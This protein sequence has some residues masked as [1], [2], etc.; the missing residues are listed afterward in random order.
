VGAVDSVKYGDV[1]TSIATQQH[2]PESV[3]HPSIQLDSET[4][5]PNP[6]PGTPQVAIQAVSCLAK[7]VFSLP[8]Y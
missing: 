4:L 2:D 1:P 5:A 7:Q 8:S 3:M 6:W